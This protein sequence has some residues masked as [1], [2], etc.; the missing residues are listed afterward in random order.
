MKSL[1]SG[2]VAGLPL[3]FFIGMAIPAE[4]IETCRT[5]TGSPSAYSYSEI[6]ASGFTC[7]LG[8]KIYSD[9]SF[10]GFSTGS[11]VFTNPISNFHTF[12]GQSLGLGPGFTGNYNYKVTIDNNMSPGFDF[13][14]F[15]T[16]T[17]LSDLGS[18]V[19]S[20]KTLS[21]GINSVSSING[22]NAPLHTYSPTV[23]G[24]ITFTSNVSVTQ[25]LMSQFT[26]T[27]IQQQ[28]PPV[29]GPFPVFGAA[30]AFGFSRQLRRRV[31]KSS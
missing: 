1:A 7:Q 14:S 31:A 12:Q 27:V 10:S 19:V 29:P 20:S 3:L 8:D 28:I 6:A 5:G 17:T 30:A 2:L 23:S 16:S 11:F 13:L 15:S 26:D 9:F 22:I 24:P 4:A 25:G 18:G 21:D